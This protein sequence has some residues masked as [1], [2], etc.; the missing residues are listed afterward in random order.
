MKDYQS[1]LILYNP[2]AMRGKI[3]EKLP[4]IKKRLLVRYPS[5]DAMVS[6][7]EDGLEELALKHAS[8]YDI[9][10]ACGGDGTIHQVINGVMKSE[11]RPLIGIL[12][13]G[14]C[15]DLSHSLDIDH[16]L[17]KAIDCI[18]RLNTTEYDLMYDGK[19]YITYSLA[20]GYLTR[21]AYTTGKNIKKRLGRFAYFV[22]ALRSLFRL[23]SFPMT[24]KV[25]GEVIDDKF[26]YFMLMNGVSAGGFRINKGENL[27]NKKVKMVAIKKTNSF[28]TF[29]RFMRLFFFG[30]KSLKKDKCVYIRDTSKIELKNHSNIPFTLD[31]EKAEFLKKNIEVKK[32]ITLIKR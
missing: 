26:A 31:G 16:D 11:S 23:K 20:T 25:D 1:V 32:S 6:P 29:F 10:V 2:N 27:D 8:K 9:I 5:V 19:D 24:I 17:D 3:D 12:P 30:I 18:L 7:N 21:S 4:Y 28:A 14:T 22:S 13:Y 15:N